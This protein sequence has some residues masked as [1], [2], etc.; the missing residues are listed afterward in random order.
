MNTK[1]YISDP[2]KL[3]KQRSRQFNRQQLFVSPVC[4]QVK[5]AHILFQLG[6]KL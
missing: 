5:M 2:A 4:L 6:L 3:S 1:F